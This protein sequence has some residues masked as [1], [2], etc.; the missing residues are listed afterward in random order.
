MCVMEARASAAEDGAGGA[1]GSTMPEAARDNLACNIYLWEETREGLGDYRFGRLA[2]ILSSV[3]PRGVWEN[4]GTSSRL[5]GS[6][7]W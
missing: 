2:Y 3:Q 4:G 7:C 6:R 1:A 5:A